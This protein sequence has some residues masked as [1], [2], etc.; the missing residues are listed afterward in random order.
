MTKILLALK[1][2]PGSK[3]RNMFPNELIQ[4]KNNQE[5]TVTH[6]WRISTIP[7]F[8]LEKIHLFLFLIH[9]CSVCMLVCAVPEEHYTLKL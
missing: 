1:I 7:L 9:W 5:I 8:L 4:Y 2:P 3:H 6:D